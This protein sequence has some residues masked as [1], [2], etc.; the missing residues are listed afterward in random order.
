MK[1]IK[2]ILAS[3]LVAF[4]VL[5]SFGFGVMIVG[6]AVVIGGAFA[7]AIRLGA[8]VIQ[9]NTEPAPKVESED[10]ANAVPA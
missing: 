8:G 1:K 9:S 5:A 3:A 7:L 6:F 2:S 4:I 10:E